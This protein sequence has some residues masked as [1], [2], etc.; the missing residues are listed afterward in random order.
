MKPSLDFT[1]ERVPTTYVGALLELAG[2]LGVPREQLLDEARVR[3][4]L[5]ENPQGRLAFADC[6]LLAGCAL[7]RC[8]EPALGPMLF[9]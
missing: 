9:A 1:A 7:S 2:E 8:E 6:H 5:L 4:K 3:P